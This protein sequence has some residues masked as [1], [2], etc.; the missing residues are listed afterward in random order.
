MNFDAVLKKFILDN[1]IN[2]KTSKSIFSQFK[3]IK[4]DGDKY[5]WC[6]ILSKESGNSKNKRYYQEL[7]KEFKQYEQ[8]LITN[9]TDIDRTPV[10]TTFSRKEISIMANCGNTMWGIIIDEETKKIYCAINIDEP[11]EYPNV[12]GG[13][14]KKYNQ[15][16]IN[17]DE[18]TIKI[19][20]QAIKGERNSIDNPKNRK[21]AS[22][23]GLDNSYRVFIFLKDK[24][25]DNMFKY[26]GEF[27]TIDVGWEKI[28]ED[29]KAYYFLMNNKLEVKNKES[30]AYNIFTKINKYS[31]EELNN[32]QKNN[33]INEEEK[34]AVVKVR[35]NQSTYRDK[36]LKIYN[37]CPLTGIRDQR[38]LIA[39]HIK[40]YHKCKDEEKYDINNGIMLSPL[41]DKLFDKFLISFDEKGNI[42]YSKN[43]LANDLELINNHFKRKYIVIKNELMLKYMKYHI[44]VF[45]E[46]NCR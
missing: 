34:H 31:D 17:K 19:Y 15:I 24:Y 46:R 30:A 5:K 22:C 2:S 9:S 41:A 8:E 10:G 20:I 43:L 1:E 32:L 14:I 38:I 21:V 16:K 39:S 36:L 3:N 35:I 4:N 44:K 11:Y 40:P 12:K 7:K 33:I 25:T 37:E 45:I 18:Q 28:D 23:S 26:L 42:M 6:S 27:I 29:Q 13:Y